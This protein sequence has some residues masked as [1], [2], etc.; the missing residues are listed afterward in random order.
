MLFQKLLG[1]SASAVVSPSFIASD[2]TQSSTSGSTLAINKPTGTVQGDLMIAFMSSGGTSTSRTWTVPSGWTE[3]VDQNTAPNFLIAYKVAGAS[4]GSSYTFT[5]SSTANDKAGTI[6]TYR[7]AAYDVVGSLSED[8]AT[9][10]L[11][12][13]TASAS[14]SV[15]IAA[16][17]RPASSITITQ[18]GGSTMTVRVTDNDGASPSFRIF[19]ES[20]PS[21]ATGTRSFDM[22]GSTQTVGTMMVIK[23]A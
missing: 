20:V 12:S 14:N 9:L 6:L 15:L 7:N 13:I 5:M 23:P 19:D 2:Q 17:F 22:G 8:A 16:L 1:I 10:T 21:G 18:N 3:I 11:S 4:E